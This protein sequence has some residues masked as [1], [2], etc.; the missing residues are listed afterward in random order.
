[1]S[2]T[3]NCPV[4]KNPRQSDG[5]GSLTEWII[6]CECD[7]AKLRESSQGLTSSICAQCGMRTR[8]SKPGSIS[9]F[10]LAADYCSCSAQSLIEF[11]ERIAAEDKLAA[12][13]SRRFDRSE[14]SGGQSADGF[15]PA[16]Q[17][18][19][20]NDLE[21]AERDAGDGDFR[22]ASS[23]SAKGQVPAALQELILQSSLNQ[24]A[25]T[26]G[27]KSRSVFA[28]VV[29]VVVVGGLAW[30]VVQLSAKLF[31]S[32]GMVSV[33][34]INY[35]EESLSERIQHYESQKW[36]LQDRGGVRFF[37]AGPGVTDD[38]F[39]L[40]IHEKNV[41]NIRALN[42][43][44]LTGRGL[45][46]LKNLAIGSLDLSS[47]EFSNEG[48]H[49]VGQLKSLEALTL[50][51]FQNI[52]ADGLREVKRLPRLKFLA[53]NHARLPPGAMSVITEL[54]GLTE[55]K[56]AVCEGDVSLELSKLTRLVNLSILRLMVQNISDQ[57]CAR[58]ADLE[59]PKL[60]N[61]DLQENQITDVGVAS[62]AKMPLEILDLSG[63]PITDES[64]VLLAANKSLKQLIVRKCNNLSKS[65][66]AS[67]CKLRPDCKFSS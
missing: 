46:H 45:T 35:A 10:V 6:T 58:L 27:K 29:V 57:E 63:N 65:G 19:A 39:V 66:K 62:L 15:P 24:E 38:D 52:S 23:P 31:H 8:E 20:E 36:N 9:Q 55:L 22:S 4:C 41:G 61:L 33:K 14:G 53:F 17:E 47:R 18:S 32:P 11:A 67:F 1:M 59:L 28:T 34:K 56:I 42:S 51:W 50:G 43:H 49:Q 25:S 2:E 48:M 30:Q 40:L 5:S 12:S 21:Q 54:T 3:E 16:G 7:L 44:S 60:R 26:V 13:T 37:D 64:L